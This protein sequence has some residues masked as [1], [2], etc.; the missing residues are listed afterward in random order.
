MV[1][2]PDHSP[3]RRLAP[4][5]VRR[6]SPALLGLIGLRERVAAVRGTVETGPTPG[7]WRIA[8]TLAAEPSEAPMITVLVVDDQSLIRQ[9]VADIL[10]HADGITVVGEAVD[11]REAVAAAARSASRRRRDGHPDAATRRHRR[12]G[13][14][15]RRPRPGLDDG[16]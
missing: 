9:A 13:G 5:D 1:T 3:A 15:L 12:D 8:A 4:R 10:S 14:D 7:G 11:G 16:C 6:G 2:N